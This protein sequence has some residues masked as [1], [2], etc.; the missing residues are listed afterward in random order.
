[1]RYRLLV[2][3]LCSFISSFC[4]GPGHQLRD[5]GPATFRPPST[6]YT[7]AGA[8]LPEYHPDDGILL[9]RTTS[10][11]QLPPHSTEESGVWASK[12]QHRPSSAPASSPRPVWLLG[13]EL[14]EVEGVPASAALPTRCATSGR[15]DL[16]KLP[17]RYMRALPQGVFEAG[18]YLQRQC[19]AARL[20]LS[21]FK[22]VV[23]EDPHPRGSQWE[24]RKAMAFLIRLA[25]E[26]CAVDEANTEAVS[27][28][29]E[30]V[31]QLHR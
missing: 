27:A 12:E 3:F 4:S 16:G 26:K 19:L 24:V 23:S 31:Y 5:G 28:I 11:R 15:E 9:P 21:C 17:E 29:V 6:T 14:P 22:R 13:L 8:G 2:L 25:E 18:Y 1:M 10:R 20:Y 30:A 7:P